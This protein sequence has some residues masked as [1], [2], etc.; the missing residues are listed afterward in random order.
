MFSHG[1]FHEIGVHHFLLFAGHVHALHE[2]N[3][4]EPVLRVD[5]HRRPP[6]S[7]MAKTACTRAFLVRQF[8]RTADAI[9]FLRAHLRVARLGDAHCGYRV[10]G[11]VTSTIEFTAAQQHLAKLAEVSCR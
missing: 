7:P 9:A 5:P 1:G 2:K 6:G 11:E 4:C 10:F 3:H 8:H